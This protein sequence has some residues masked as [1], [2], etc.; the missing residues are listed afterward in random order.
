MTI[1]NKLT[2]AIGVGALTGA[3]LVAAAPTT[4]AAQTSNGPTIGAYAQPING[5][6]NIDAI[7]ELEQTLGTTLPIVRAF[8]DWDDTIGA[9]KPLHV[10][11]RDGGRELALSVKPTRQDKTDIPWASIAAAQ[12]GSRIYQE[13]QTMADAL[14]RYDAP[15]IFTFHHE[16]EQGAHRT[17]GGGNTRFGDADDFK[18]AYRKVH[19]IFQ[20]EGVD[21]VRYSVVLTEWSFEVGEFSPN[22]E[23]RAELWY[24]GDDV[25]DIIGSD[26]YNWN[27][28][29]PGN[30]N[31]PWISLEDDIAPLLRWANE[32]QPDKQ[33]MLGEFGSDEGSPGQKAQWLADAQEWFETSPDAD[34]FA[35]ILYFH[36]DGREE[37]WPDCEWWLDSSTSSTSQAIDWF[38]NSRFR[39]SFTNNFGST[40]NHTCFGEPAT[41]VGTAGNDTIVGTAGKDVIVGLEGNDNIEGLTGDDLICGGPGNDTI[42][43]LGGEDSIHGQAGAD[44][45]FGGNSPDLLLGGDGNDRIDGNAG[46]DEIHG[47]DGKDTISGGSQGDTIYGQAG[48]DQINGNKGFDRILGGKGTDFVLG[49]QGNDNLL[50]NLG[51]DTCV[52]GLGSDSVDCEI[53][54]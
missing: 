11:T 51:T 18:A 30:D 19:S 16:P 46:A 24:P 5:Q 34:R 7:V 49:G 44:R 8:S 41:I 27:N 9:D 48:A 4:A 14:N 25:V 47:N 53:R 22:D 39:G 21:N 54:R 3:L 40:S 32:H 33:L 38:N 29:R 35:A 26:E 31:D 13:I 45:I 43:G 10:F 17:D 37:G 36:D 28:C 52:A 6:S 1:L 15:V 2:A 12:P 23:R 50:G 42:Y 20:S